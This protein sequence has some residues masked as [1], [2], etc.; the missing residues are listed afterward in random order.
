MKFD[1]DRW[2]FV[3]RHIYRFLVDTLQNIRI[4]RFTKIQWSKSNFIWRNRC[5][6]TLNI[7][8]RAKKKQISLSTFRG[9]AQK[10]ATSAIK[11]FNI[12]Q[13]KRDKLVKCY[14]RTNCSHFCK[15][16][17]R[18]FSFSSFARWFQVYHPKHKFK[19]ILSNIY[20]LQKLN[21]YLSD[22]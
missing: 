7:W 16:K 20:K 15:G 10:N 3:K 22:T 2:I 6:Y 11:S 14:I 13:Y 21:W 12:L 9:T 19:K 1:F 4:W 8:G 5:F 18:R 17:L